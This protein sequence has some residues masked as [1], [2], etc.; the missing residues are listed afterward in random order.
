MPF[1]FVKSLLE[2]EPQLL[3][4]MKETSESRN[5]GPKAYKR[6]VES[7]GDELSR[8]LFLEEF[9]DASGSTAS[10]AHG[11]NHGRGSKHDVTAGEYAGD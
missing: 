4:L 7:P 1:L 8:S 5:P 6:Y 2:K 10:L 3:V 11:E 9:V